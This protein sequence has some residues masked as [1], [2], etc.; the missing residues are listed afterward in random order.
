MGTERANGHPRLFL[1]NKSLH[2]TLLRWRYAMLVSSV[3]SWRKR[4]LFMFKRYGL[5]FLV[6]I[7]FFI[8]A[9]NEIQENNK[10]QIPVFVIASANDNTIHIGNPI[11]ITIKLINNFTSSIHFNT[12]SLTQNEWNGETINLSLVDIFRDNKPDNLYLDRPKIDVPVEISG[13]GY[14]IVKPKGELIIQ[15]DARKWKLRDGWLPGKYKITVRIDNITLDK[16]SK[17]SVLSEPFDL[18]IR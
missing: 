17:L 6:I 4:G 10:R 16:F 14:K 15:T 13:M 1:P 5:I 11:P 7:P 18:E 3:V 2:R 8:A 9:T 12:F